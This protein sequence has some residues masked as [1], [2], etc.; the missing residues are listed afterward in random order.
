MIREATGYERLLKEGDHIK[1]ASK[2]TYVHNKA[3]NVNA[4]E[5]FYPTMPSSSQLDQEWSAEEG[6]DGKGVSAIELTSKKP[7]KCKTLKLIKEPMKLKS[8]A[9]A[10]PKFDSYTYSAN[11]AAEILDDLFQAGMVKTDYGVIP[12]ADQLKGKKFC[13]FHNLWN[14][15][16]F[17]CV[18]LK[19]QIQVWL[20]SGRIEMEIPPKAATLVNSDPFPQVEVNMVEVQWPNQGQEG[21]E[22]EPEEKKTK[23]REEKAFV[24][25]LCRRCK[26]ECNLESDDEI[27]PKKSQTLKPS[28]KF[29]QPHSP[30]ER[31]IQFDDREPVT[32]TVRR[33]EQGES[34]RQGPRDSNLFLRNNYWNQSRTEPARGGYE[35]TR[36]FY[37]NKSGGKITAKQTP[38]FS[39]EPYIPPF[40]NPISATGP[41]KAE[42]ASK[43]FRPI[44]S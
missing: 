25:I 26:R 30:R 9:F 42:S 32:K 15:N 36:R 18:K 34:S 8:V 33:F 1:N 12:K 7:A 23:P 19:D 14:H 20:N 17:E 39:T 40:S 27:T 16:T 11:K 29:F 44:R 38:Q 31:R 13:K 37:E 21:D 10:K 35:E 41:Y 2:G 28:A 43:I 24:V 6:D 4:L 3:R 22:K 5:I